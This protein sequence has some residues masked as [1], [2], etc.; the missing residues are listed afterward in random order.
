MLSELPAATKS[1][2][3]HPGELEYRIRRFTQPR[4]TR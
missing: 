1:R 2:R 3:G 4:L